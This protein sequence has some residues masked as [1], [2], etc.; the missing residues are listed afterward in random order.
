MAGDEWR[1]RKRKRHAEGD[2]AAASHPSGDVD[3]VAENPDCSQGM[4]DRDTAG[5]PILLQSLSC[6]SVRT[7]YCKYLSG[8]NSHSKPTRFV[9]SLRNVG[10]RRPCG[11]S[12]CHAKQLERVR[13]RGSSSSHPV[14]T[15]AL[16]SAARNRVP[17]QIVHAFVRGWIDKQRSANAERRL[18]F[19]DVFCG[20]GSVSDAVKEMGEDVV[21]VS[22]DIRPRRY[23]KG[24]PLNFDMSITP[25]HT[26][27][28]VALAREGLRETED[29][30][31]LYWIS[32][33]CETYSLQARAVHR[34]R[35]GPPSEP[36]L[37][38]D[39]MNRRLVDELIQTCSQ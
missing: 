10:L 30:A 24:R 31:V 12:P 34:P 16:S 18:F 25:L 35:A 1:T 32:S 36:A 5:W 15:C 9:T 14:R 13:S 29:C 39:A 19:V 7:S 27:K 17:T 22:N 3:F 37:Q 2:G 28:A 4:F 11:Q 23:A 38:H 6:A 21:V 20:W 26:L 8:D 33:P